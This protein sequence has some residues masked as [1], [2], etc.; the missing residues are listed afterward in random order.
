MSTASSPSSR[1]QVAT[2]ASSPACLRSAK[3]A[4][5][6]SRLE[7]RQTGIQTDKPTNR[8]DTQKDEDRQTYRQTDRQ[9]DRMDRQNRQTHRHTDRQTDRQTGRQ[10]DRQADRQTDRTGR[11]NV[12]ADTRKTDALCVANETCVVCRLTGWKVCLWSLDFVCCLFSLT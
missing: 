7:D 4:E 3:P 9:T 5:Y 1:L 11:Q 2:F 12:Q 10:T 8:T 6:K